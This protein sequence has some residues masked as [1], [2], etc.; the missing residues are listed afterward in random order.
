MNSQLFV[1]VLPTTFERT[2]SK[3]KSTVPLKDLIKCEMVKGYDKRLVILF[4]VEGKEKA[5]EYETKDVKTAAEI[6]AKISYVL[7]TILYL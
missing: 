4:N 2:K 5:I 1:D 3:T 6:V 7:V